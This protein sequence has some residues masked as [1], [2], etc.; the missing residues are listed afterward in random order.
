MDNIL[1]V[2]F[3]LADFSYLELGTIGRTS[4]AELCNI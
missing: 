2:P 4:L 3:D 1:N